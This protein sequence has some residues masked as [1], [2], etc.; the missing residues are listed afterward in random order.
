LTKMRSPGK[1]AKPS[2]FPQTTLTSSY[3]RTNP[4]KTNQIPL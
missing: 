3:K 1:Y 4:W 2:A